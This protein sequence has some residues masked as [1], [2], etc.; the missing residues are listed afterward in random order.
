MPDPR[1][2]C[3]IQ[4]AVP[5]RATDD[6]YL[7]TI[8]GAGGLETIEAICRPHTGV[9]DDQVRKAGGTIIGARALEGIEATP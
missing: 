5:C 6:L 4:Q 1:Y 3:Q 7:L 9:R 8:R 2:A